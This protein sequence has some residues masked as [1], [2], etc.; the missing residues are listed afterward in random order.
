MCTTSGVA[1]LRREKRKPT[2][3]EA[4]CWRLPSKASSPWARRKAAKRSMRAAAGNTQFPPTLH[5]PI[6]ACVIF[7]LSLVSHIC[8]YLEEAYQKSGCQPLVGGGVELVGGEGVGQGSEVGRGE[9]VG[10]KGESTIGPALVG[11][12]GEGGAGVDGGLAVRD[13]A[14]ELGGPNGALRQLHSRFLNPL[15]TYLWPSV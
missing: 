7:L 12:V 10:R 13:A 5:M 11:G 4:S 6:R 14:P 9:G 2:T 1:S 3:A 8:H 15:H